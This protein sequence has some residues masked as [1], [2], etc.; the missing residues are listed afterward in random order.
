MR[1]EGRGPVRQWWIVRTEMMH[2]PLKEEEISQ[3]LREA[4]D[5]LPTV[6]ESVEVVEM[7][8]ADQAHFNAL[9]ELR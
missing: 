7:P 4:L 3:I 8:E 9:I 5:P 6:N 1:S 2:A